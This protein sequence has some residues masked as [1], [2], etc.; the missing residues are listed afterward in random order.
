MNPLETLRI[1]A[2]ALLRNKTRSFL[3]ALGII[4]G[5][6][7]VIAMMAIGEGAKQMIVAQF[8]AMGANLII[9]LPGSTNTG[10]ARGGAG[11]A[12]SIT[13][14]DLKA[15]QT[16]VPTMLAAAPVLRINT[17]VVGEEQNWP[18]QVIGTT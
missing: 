12:S 3:T 1:A 2:I 5:V 13:W 16:Q 18:T 14:D 15:I 9:L 4:I 11:S 8:S 17:M 7:A 6:A 10:G